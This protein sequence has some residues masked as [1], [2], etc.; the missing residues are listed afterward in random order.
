MRVYTVSGSN[1]E[2]TSGVKS[3]CGYNEASSSAL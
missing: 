3:D 1:L 2:T